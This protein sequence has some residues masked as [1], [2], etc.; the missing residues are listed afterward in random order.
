MARREASVMIEN[1]R[2]TSGIWSMGAEEKIHF[3]SLKAVCWR[4]VHFHGSSF[5]VRRFRGAT[6]LEKLGMNFL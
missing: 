1:G 4:G 5:L 6:M 2:V 3:S